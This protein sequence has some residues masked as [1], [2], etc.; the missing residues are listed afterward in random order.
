VEQRAPLF[1]LDASHIR[2]TPSTWVCI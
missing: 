1:N 2:S